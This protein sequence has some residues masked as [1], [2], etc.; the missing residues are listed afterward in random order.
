MRLSAGLFVLRYVSSNDAGVAPAV[1]VSAPA[2]S[3][4]DVITHDYA[5]FGLMAAPGE[6]VVVRASK[7]SH[8]TVNILPSAGSDNNHAH[9]VLE[10]VSATGMDGLSS[11][12]VV[13]QQ[14]ALS[15]AD[16]GDIE[17]LA[18]VA[19][20]GD[21][22]AQLGEW[23]CGPDL[24][25]SIEGLELIWRGRPSGL[26]ISV[27][28]TQLVRGRRQQFPAG[29]AGSFV[30]SRGKAVPL[31]GIVLALNGSMADRFELECEALFLGAQI[32]RRKGA[33]V[34]LS[35]PTG[36]EPLVGL[37]VQLWPVVMAPR[38]TAPM[39]ER[40]HYAGA[41]QQTVDPA[42][43]AFPVAGASGRVRI[44][45]TPRAGSALNHS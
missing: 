24:P 31:A 39:A 34:D 45:R 21:I 1:R 9:L 5:D 15:D 11:S 4:V 12:I 14:P 27:S 18:H 6:A 23:I 32:V 36:L 28:A 43:G 2:G 17:I 22:V 41:A 42:G 19:R 26:N 25:M 33:V 20:R 35:G 3:G 13:M 30:G 37:K 40:V 16:A 38:P 44:F 8:L 7:P 29:V 10:R